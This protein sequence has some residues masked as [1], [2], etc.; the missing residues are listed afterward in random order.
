MRGI[1]SSCLT[2][3]LSLV[4][5]RTRSSSVMSASGSPPTATRSPNFPGSNSTHPCWSRNVAEL[6]QSSLAVLSFLVAVARQRL[7]SA[8]TSAFCSFRWSFLILLHQKGVNFRGFDAQPKLHPYQGAAPSFLSFCWA[9]SRITWRHASESLVSEASRTNAFSAY[10][11]ARSFCP[12]AKYTS[13][14]LS[15]ALADSG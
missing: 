9:L 12:S 1:V 8:T 6:A 3:W 5:K 13:E 14:R 7:P 11:R 4:T 15:L 10:C 2:T